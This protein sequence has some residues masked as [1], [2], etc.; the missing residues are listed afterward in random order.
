MTGMADECVLDNYRHILRT[1]LDAGYR[2]IPF[3]AIGKE[4]SPRT[5]LLRHDVDSELLGCHAML[6][7]E[8][9]TNVRATYFLMLR[10]TAYNLFSVE[11]RAVVSRMLAEGHQIGLHFMGELCEGD[12]AATLS[13]KVLR[14]GRWMR[15][16]FGVDI[17]A[18]SFH[19]PTR[20]ILEADLFIPGLVNTYNRQQMGPYFYLADTNMQWRSGHPIDLFRSATHMRVQLLIHPMWWTATPTDVRGKWTAVLDRNRAVVVSHWKVRERTLAS[21]DLD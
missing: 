17:D 13:E 4:D 8:R 16:E 1:A 6:E 2:F 14:E 10:S 3:S 18:V 20:A 5:C 12:D 11:A 19:Q 21:L 9:E 15:E 7:V